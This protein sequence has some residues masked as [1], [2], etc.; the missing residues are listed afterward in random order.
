MEYNRIVDEWLEIDD[1]IREIRKQEKEFRDR[2]AKM[3]I[4][5]ISNVDKIPKEK[6]PIRF[7]QKN[8]VEPL[9]FRY[10]ERVLGDI[11][12]GEEKVIKIINMIKQKRE[13]KQEWDIKRSTK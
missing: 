7:V 3:E 13:V 10:L 5:L 6:L 8:V 1:K 9:T 2:Q 11:V 12:Q 4:W